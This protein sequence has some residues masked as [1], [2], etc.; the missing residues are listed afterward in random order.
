MLF[1]FFLNL[2]HVLMCVFTYKKDP[3]CTA[4]TDPTRGGGLGWPGPA[5][6]AAAVEQQQTKQTP[7]TANAVY[8]FRSP[9]PLAGG[10]RALG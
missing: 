3:I 1:F 10:A 6:A 7:C 9:S 4:R 2:L 8:V 5:R